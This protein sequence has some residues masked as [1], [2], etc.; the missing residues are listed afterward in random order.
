MSKFL[1]MMEVEVDHPNVN[2]DAIKEW[3]GGA[4]K[5]LVG[6]GARREVVHDN[7]WGEEIPTGSFYYTN[8]WYPVKIG[9]IMAVQDRPT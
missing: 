5:Q 2:T 4:T 8:G 6:V 1:I 7:D 3:V 9:T